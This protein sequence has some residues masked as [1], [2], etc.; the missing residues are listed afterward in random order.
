MALRTT[1]ARARE[2]IDRAH[3]AG[4]LCP[5]G[6]REFVGLFRHVGGEREF[7]RQW[8]H[9]VRGTQAPARVRG[10]WR[11]QVVG[12][13]HRIS[14]AHPC[15]KNV[16]LPGGERLRILEPVTWVLD[17]PRRHMTGDELGADRFSPRDGILVGQERHRRHAAGHVAPAA[18]I[19]DD[20]KDV[21][22]VGVGR[23]DGFVG[24]AAAGPRA[25]SPRAPSR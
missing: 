13:A 8:K 14:A 2:E 7:G 4:L 25:R 9:Q 24:F 3:P 5:G 21:F 6:Q 16:Q 15:Q 23:G 17:A 19:A 18:S 20:R 22:V 11:R 12:V 1:A 10:D